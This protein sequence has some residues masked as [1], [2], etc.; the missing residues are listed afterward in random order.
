MR[1]KKTFNNILW[2]FAYQLVAI[3]CGFIVPRL[4]LTS[5]GSQYN[6][7]TSAVTQF[8]QV[9]ALFQAGIGGVTMA[10][11]YKPLAESD[12][13]KISIIVKSTEEFMRKIVLIFIVFTL[14]LAFIKTGPASSGK[15]LEVPPICTC[16]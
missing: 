15:V 5:F 7:V 10:A 9:I 16:A 12:P 11:L 2:G 14:L 13:M 8:M 1:V 6:G 4:V 3:L